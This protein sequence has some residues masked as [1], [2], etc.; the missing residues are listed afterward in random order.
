MR[1]FRSLN[2]IA[3]SLICFCEADPYYVKP[4]DEGNVAVLIVYVDELILTKDD[5]PQI[6]WLKISLSAEFEIKDPR[7]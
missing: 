7:L 5:L 2:S 1:G 6:N 4:S 3:K